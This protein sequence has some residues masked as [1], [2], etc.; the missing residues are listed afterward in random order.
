MN[1]GL[2]E[3]VSIVLLKFFLFIIFNIYKIYK[4]GFLFGIA[5]SCV[6]RGYISI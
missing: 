4:D 6:E 5:Y 1:K 2:K 3:K